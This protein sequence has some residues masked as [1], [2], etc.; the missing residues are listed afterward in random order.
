MGVLSES[1]FGLTL[2]GQ[3]VDTQAQPIQGAEVV[4][5]ERYSV[6]LSFRFANVITPIVKTDAQGRFVFELDPALSEDVSHQRDIFVVARKAGLACAWDWLNG[7]PNTRARRDFPLV[8]EPV[9]ELGG[10]VVDAWGVPVAGAEVQALSLTYSGFSEGNNTWRVSGPKAWFSVT[11]DALGRFR[12]NQLS[13]DTNANASLRV[14]VP[15]SPHSYDF[16]RGSDKGFWVGQSDICLKLPKVGAVTGQVRDDRGRPVPGVDLKIGSSLAP[17]DMLYKDRMT[18]ADAQGF[19]SFDAIPEGSHWIEVC[20]HGKDS[21]PW[22]GQRVDVSVKAGQTSKRAVVRV[23]KGGMFHFTVRDTQTR[24]PLEGIKVSAANNV[25]SRNGMITDSQGRARIRC[26][27]G[28]YSISLGGDR[29]NLWMAMGAVSS[30][31]TVPVTALVNSI[32]KVTGTV[33]D[34]QNRPVSH[35]LVIVGGGDHVV[36]DVDGR[37]SAYCSK[38][39]SAKSVWVMAR[40]P[41]HGL[42][43][44]MH[45]TDLSRPV[46]LQLKPAWTLVGQVIDPQGRAVCA[47]RVHLTG[48][49][50]MDERVLTDGQGR[51]TLTAIPPKQPGFDYRLTINAAGYGPGKSR[52]IESQELGGETLDMGNFLLVPATESV[53]GYV[54]NA[55]GMPVPGVEFF[56]NSID[57]LVPQYP[58]STAADEQGRFRLRHLCKGAIKIMIWTYDENHLLNSETTLT[59]QVPAENVKIV[60]GKDLSLMNESS[61]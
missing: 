20:G 41:E 5:C 49:T 53:S 59:L 21:D 48:I 55:Q 25:W 26:I 16:Y 1:C 46:T 31:Q 9:G 13:V 47:A 51:F 7:A 38:V 18:C 10:Q 34:M 54:V 28:R 22:V 39:G 11:T 2:T 56:V 61:Y 42:A 14:S 4:V 43:A 24:Q 12:F 33:V 36:T 30:G 15:G 60:L 57:D 37:F 19:F 45:V 29:T 8:L 17:H 23:I 44:L 6:G 40:D 27:P 35:A 52:R 50:G 32:P 3:V 58:N